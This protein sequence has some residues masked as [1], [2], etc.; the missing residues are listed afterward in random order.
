MVYIGHSMGG[1]LARL[2]V[3]DSGDVLWNDLLANYDLKGERLRGA[4]QAGAAAAFQGA[5]ERGTRDL[6]RRAAPGHGY[7]RQQGRAA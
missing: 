5:A 3:S 7:R 6:H 2:L 1:V 4:G